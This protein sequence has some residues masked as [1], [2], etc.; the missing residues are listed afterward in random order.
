MRLLPAQKWKRVLLVVTNLAILLIAPFEW[1]WVCITLGFPHYS[2]DR[3]C[4]FV[5]FLLFDLNWLFGLTFGSGLIAAI[6]VGRDGLRGRSRRKAQFALGAALALYAIN[7]LALIE[8][9]NGDDLL[10]RIES[11]FAN[12][13]IG[14]PPLSPTWIIP[15]GRVFF[16]QPVRGMNVRF[17]PG[18]TG[19]FFCDSRSFVFVQST[20]VTIWPLFAVAVGGA[21]GA[22]VRKQPKKG[23]QAC[24][25]GY[26]LTGNLSG[27]CPEC[28]EGISTSGS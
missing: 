19:N 9:G 21:A 3:A 17:A 6:V 11:G 26:D 16:E 12:L 22:L 13:S 24:P 28:G 4:E 10:L 14:T 8:V 27:T 15:Y 20:F 2:A 18:I 23:P 7:H 25:C 1:R 5:Q